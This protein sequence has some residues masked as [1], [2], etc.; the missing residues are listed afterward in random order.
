MTNEQGQ[1]MTRTRG[2]TLIELLVVVAIIAILAAIA[3]PAY[4]RYTYRSR[5]V[6]GQD[7]LLRIANA[8]ERYYATNNKY[9]ALTDIGF[10]NPAPSDKGFYSA[11]VAMTGPAGS[12]SQG[13]TATATP[14]GVQ[15]AD[16]C[17]TLTL[18][19]AGVKTPGPASAAS[20]A[21]GNCW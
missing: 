11:T 14:L 8:Q 2:F 13:F 3:I 17:S 4:S 15:A 5:R 16:A 7:L 18:N 21:N 19:D 9:G 12:S 1:L 6:D 10:A 20:N